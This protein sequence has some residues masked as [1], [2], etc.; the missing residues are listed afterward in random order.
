MTELFEPAHRY[1]PIIYA[2]TYFEKNWRY[3]GI[4][5][6]G[7]TFRIFRT[8]AS[9]S[10]V[11]LICSFRRRRNMLGKRDWVEGSIH[12]ICV[13]SRKGLHFQMWV[14]EELIRSNSS[15]KVGS[16]SIPP[17]RCWI[18]LVTTFTKFVKS[19]QSPRP[20]FKDGDPCERV[21]QIIYYLPRRGFQYSSPS[22]NSQSDD[23]STRN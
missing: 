14:F 18:S 2:Y 11:I 13:W 23:P 15:K 10:L 22:S 3:L 17:P 19:L 8:A 1:L 20:S 16:P 9:K 21:I 5:P 6:Q 12:T 4:G 7:G